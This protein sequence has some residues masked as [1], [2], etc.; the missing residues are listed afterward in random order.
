M[1]L[2]ADEC[3]NISN[4][5]KQFQSNLSKMHKYVDLLE[6]EKKTNSVDNFL[7]HSYPTKFS[8]P[9]FSTNRNWCT[10]RSEKTFKQHLS[11][12]SD[13]PASPHNILF[14]FLFHISQY[15]G[16]IFG[17]F[18]RDFLVPVLIYS[19]NVTFWQSNLWYEIY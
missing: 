3:K 15:N 4:I 17:G 12:S 13:L 18:V 7:H 8:P 11:N 14:N 9:L 1:S 6:N 2:I 5:G 16:Y 10:K 19:Q